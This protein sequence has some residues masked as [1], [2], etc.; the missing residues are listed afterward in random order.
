MFPIS[1]IFLDSKDPIVLFQSVKNC[2]LDIASYDRIVVIA[3]L[4]TTVLRKHDI[5]DDL[6]LSFLAREIELY[7]NDVS[8]SA[9]ELKM[10][11]ER[12]EGMLP[13]ITTSTLFLERG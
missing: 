10:Q 2:I 11:K 4:L 5:K 9:L 12:I 6:Y 1:G 7:G 13:Q 8:S 3:Q